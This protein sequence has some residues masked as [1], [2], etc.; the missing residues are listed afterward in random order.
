MTFADAALPVFS[1]DVDERRVDALQVENGGASL[2]AQEVAH[3]VTH[4]TVIVV[5]EFR[6]NKKQTHQ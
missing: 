2:A 5:V 4:A 1:G 6:C 3:A